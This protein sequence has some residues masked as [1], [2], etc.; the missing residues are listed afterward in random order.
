MPF[1]QPDPDDITQGGEYDQIVRESVKRFKDRYSFIAFGALLAEY[2]TEV[3]RVVNETYAVR[4][5]L[6][7]KVAPQNQPK[8]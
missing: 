7:L 2:E 1:T 8:K 5:A 4:C 6:L 3:R